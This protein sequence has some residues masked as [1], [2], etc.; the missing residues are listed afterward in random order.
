MKHTLSLNT[1]NG[2]S[3]TAGLMLSMC[4]HKVATWSLVILK[5]IHYS[6]LFV[7]KMS[8]TGKRSLNHLIC[9]QHSNANQEKNYLGHF[10]SFSTHNQHSISNMSRGIQ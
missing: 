1:V 10:K 2:P 6:S 8:T 9:Q 4:G 3:P 7:S 5:T